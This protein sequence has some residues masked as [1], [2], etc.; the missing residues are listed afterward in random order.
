MPTVYQAATFSVHVKNKL[1][2]SFKSPL[3]AWHYV[4]TPIF[5]MRKLRHGGGSTSLKLQSQDLN[6]RNS[7]TRS[8]PLHLLIFFLYFSTFCNFSI[9]AMQPSNKPKKKKCFLINS[10][11]KAQSHFPNHHSNKQSFLLAPPH[12]RNPQ[13]KKAAKLGPYFPLR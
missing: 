3:F 13:W 12:S 11:G 8:E 5:H 6:L 10:Q 7:S 9:L 4:I 2:Y 1:I